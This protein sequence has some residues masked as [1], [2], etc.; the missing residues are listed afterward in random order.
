NRIVI[1]ERP[2][3]SEEQLLDRVRERLA[4]KVEHEIRHISARERV[5]KID[6]LIP[7]V[8]KM[9]DTEEGRRELAAICASY[10]QE[11]RPETTVDEESARQAEESRERGEP[12]GSGDS[13]RGGGDARRG[14][15]GRGRGRRPRRRR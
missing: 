7:M 13:R 5:Q 11:H 2:L 1:E 9:A 14:G 12:H 8:Q 15:G 6:R 4:V 10:L 3:P